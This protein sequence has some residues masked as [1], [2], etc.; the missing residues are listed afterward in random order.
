MC[1]GNLGSCKTIDRSEEADCAAVLLPIMVC[2]SHTLSIRQAQLTSSLRH[3]TSDTILASA[4]L[5]TELIHEHELT[6]RANLSQDIEFAIGL[7]NESARMGDEM[8][9]R[10]TTLLRRLIQHD[11]STRMPNADHDLQDLQQDWLSN[12]EMGW[13]DWTA[14][15]NDDFPDVLLWDQ[16]D[17]Q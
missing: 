12:L 3:I 17:M 2:R 9:A 13:L 10:G 7:L 11:A 6:E 16:F 15:N 8:A 14:P 4:V 1:I 5:A